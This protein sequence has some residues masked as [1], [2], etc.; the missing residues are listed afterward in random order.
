MAVDVIKP[1]QNTCFGRGCPGN[2][3]GLAVQT[4]KKRGDDGRHV[5]PGAYLFQ[6]KLKQDLPAPGEA[7]APIP[8]K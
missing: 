5:G 3:E 1:L 8:T 2:H 4:G 7:G 6:F